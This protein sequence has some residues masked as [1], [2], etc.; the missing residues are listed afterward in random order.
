MHSGMFLLS[1]LDVVTLNP[2]KK[3]ATI[4]LASITF[5]ALPGLD[6]VSRT[7]GFIAIVGSFASLG[8][9][10][11]AAFRNNVEVQRWAARG[12]EGIVVSMSTLTV[13]FLYPRSKRK[14]SIHF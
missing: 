3:A 12:G 10:M 4:L 8:A 7:A 5:L 13:S 6:N 1:A 11:I 9:S 14:H 2:V